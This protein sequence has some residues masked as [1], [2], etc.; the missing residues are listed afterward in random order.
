MKHIL[1]IARKEFLDTLRDKRTLIV[2]IVVPL[3]LFPVVFSLVNNI[4]QSSMQEAQSRTINLGVMDQQASDD[5]FDFIRKHESVKLVTLNSRDSIQ[6]LIKQDSLHAALILSDTYEQNLQGMKTAVIDFYF[7]STEEGIEGRMLELIRSYEDGLMQMRLEE[8]QVS[9]SVVNP[10]DINQKD[11]ATLQEK[12]GKFAGGL[13]PYVFIIFCFIGAMYPAIDLFTG[14]KE[15]MT[16]ETILTTPVKRIQILTGKMMVVV[17]T[18]IFSA[19]LAIV[20]LFAGLNFV[21]ALPAELLDVAGDILQVEFI[22]L[23]LSMLIPLTIFFAGILIPIAIYAKSFKEAQSIITPI[24]IVVI[25]PAIIGMLPGVELSLQTAFIPVVNI[26]MATKEIIAGTI[27]YSLLAVVYASLITFAIV[28]V[29]F[30]VR[31][32]S[33]ENNILRI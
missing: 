15:R 18:G 32:F 9:P 13:M 2:M 33:K 4:Q 29:T 3:L 21:E 1:N 8:I 19:L 10:I 6:K 28:S 17:V 24:N 16:I 14:E 26:A 25:L 30:S 20:G 23:L 27:D 7:E 31:Y 5:L 22:L 12:I 11:M